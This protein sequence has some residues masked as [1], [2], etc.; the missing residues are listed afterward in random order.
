MTPQVTVIMPYVRPALAK[1]C[2]DLIRKH[3]GA[4]YIL[5]AEEDTERIGC[6]KM[7]K[8]LTDRAATPII[9]YID[10]D[11][12]PEK[13]FLKLGLE[14]MET[15]EDEW[16]LVGFGDRLP[17]E[18]AGQW[19]GHKRLLTEVLDGEF[20]HTGYYHC[21]CDMEL[22][23]RC[24]R[25]GRYIKSERA[26]VLHDHPI[27]RGEATAD[28]DYLRCYAPKRVLQDRKLFVQRMKT[29]LKEGDE[30][31]SDPAL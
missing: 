13:D 7:V 16:G 4:P 17:R 23:V 31:T 15:F 11:A 6:P 30:K 8:R 25:V 21:C 2:Q 10:D 27:L 5:L 19:L 18:F 28:P 9:C 26:F 14:D 24:R 3:A 20:F 22:T 1:R 29:L 12:L